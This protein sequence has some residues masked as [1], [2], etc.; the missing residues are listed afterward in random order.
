MVPTW[1]WL[2]AAVVLVLGAAWGVRNQIN[3]FL[4]QRGLLTLGGAGAGSSG[5]KPRIWWY[6]DD[7]QPNT[8]VWLDWGNRATLQPNEPYLQVGLARA[9]VLWGHEFEIVPVM[10]RGMATADLAKAGIT[11]PEGADRCPPYLWMAW[12]RAAYLTGHGGLWLDG[13]VLPIADGG[14]L[15]RRVSGHGA[16]TFGVDP[17]EGLSA[18]EAGLPAAGP[19]AGWAATP[20]HPVWS[21]LMRDVAALIAMGAQ[22]WESPEARRSLRHLWDKHCSGTVRVDRPAEVSRDRYGRRLE[23]DTLLGQTEWQSGSTKDG[24]WVPLPD[25]RD[26]LSRAVPWRWFELLS[27]E[28]IR[29]SD[30]VWARWATGQ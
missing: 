15:L 4:G 11:M 17:A 2:V 13:S 16:L 26:G 10:G 19:S 14:A 18:A 25:G 28:E 3:A 6:V 24:L 27:A 30:F 20:N 7:G 8:H 22:S 12:C 1:I 29:E 5:G 9:R 23:L 21:G